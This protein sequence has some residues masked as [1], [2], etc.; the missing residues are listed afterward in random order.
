MPRVSVAIVGGGVSG[1][2]LARHLH[3]RQVPYQ[4]VDAAPRLGGKF[5]TTHVEN[6][7]GAWLLEEGPNSFGD[8]SKALVGL[9]EAAGLGD[10]LV[11][12]PDYAGKR[13]IVRAGRL[14][15]VP[16]KPPLMLISQVLP[17]S[18]RLRLMLEPFIS[19]SSSDD[20]EE[21]LAEFC[22]RRLGRQARLGLLTPVVSGIYAG[23]PE[24][25]G[26]ESAFPA[27]VAL[28]REHGSLIRAAM[29]GSGPPNRGRLSSLRLG[30]AQLPDTLAETLG[31]AAR[32]GCAAK[33]VRPV[34]GGYEVLLDGGER[35][36]AGE[37]VLAT[38]ARATADLVE[39]MS[40][41]AAKEL[42]AIKYAP[43]C[44]VHVGLP[45]A[46]VPELPGGFGFLAPRSQGVRILGAIFSS[47]LFP[48]RAPDGHHL[49]TIF[50]GGRIDR[51]GASLTD[52]ELR[53]TVLAD[54]GLVLGVKGE[55][56][57][58]SVTR[59]DAAIPQYVVGHKD[60]VERIRC[61]LAPQR[62]LHLLGNWQGGI[63]M[64]A[65][66]ENADTLADKIAPRGGASDGAQA[67]AAP[68]V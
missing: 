57:L 51:E 26:A 47:T 10:E 20:P 16:A 40:G 9:V 17:L 59:W 54:L 34:G 53:R 67:G 64:P 32:A 42:R 36:E 5:R 1:L 58:F 45:D 19:P 27:M 2:A 7:H 50:V 18:G 3:E 25:L 30:L 31:D 28:E 48:G 21:S 68:R 46:A 15:E 44:V 23:D 43:M 61:A 65:C 35:L 13:F 66:V 55:P 38:T 6:E 60:R 62:G 22:D 63:A 41:E 14:V 29:K 33:Q 39:S 37:V 52:A 49:L 24:E 11:R 56:S 8:A 12:A 4:L